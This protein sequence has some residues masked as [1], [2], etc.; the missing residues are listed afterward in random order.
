M[1]FQN[2]WV[3]NY[4]TAAYIKMPL[5]PPATVEATA[6]KAAAE[7][8]WEFETI[9][10]DDRLLRALIAG[11]WSEDEFLIVPPGQS[12]SPSHDDC[13]LRAVPKG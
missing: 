12:I 9:E 5:N 6:R 4:T 2:K 13:I 1:E 7:A 3:E 10:G 11:D 8:G